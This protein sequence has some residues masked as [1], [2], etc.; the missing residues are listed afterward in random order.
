MRYDI[1]IAE[2]MTTALFW[3]AYSSILKMEEVYSFKMWV[4][5][6]QT[7]QHHNL[8]ESNFKDSLVVWSTFHFT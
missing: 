3:V 7:T 8:D 2:T 1:L 5:F 4:S 6:Y